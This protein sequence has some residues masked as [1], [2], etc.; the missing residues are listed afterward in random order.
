MLGWLL[1]VFGLIENVHAGSSLPRFLMRALPPGATRPL[2]MIDRADVLA[3]GRAFRRVFESDATIFDQQAVGPA[4][5]TQ[6]NNT[7][8][9]WAWACFVDIRDIPKDAQNLHLLG[10]RQVGF[11]DTVWNST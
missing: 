11:G 4:I 10:R 1:V 2:P 5:M 3:R 9:V 7:C 8:T 6:L